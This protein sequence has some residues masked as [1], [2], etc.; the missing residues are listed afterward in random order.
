ML[1]NAEHNCI[2]LPEEKRRTARRFCLC[3]SSQFL[4]QPHLSSH[5]RAAHLIE[6]PVLAGSRPESNNPVPR[7]GAGH[8]NFHHPLALEN[9]LRRANTTDR[10]LPERYILYRE[11]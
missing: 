10:R 3:A 7:R 5:A 11:W 9:K 4:K 1:E 8:N 6:R 2:S